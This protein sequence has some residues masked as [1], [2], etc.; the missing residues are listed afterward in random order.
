MGNLQIKNLPDQLHA[1]L[2]RRARRRGVSMRDYVLALIER[3]QRRQSTS[4]WLDE[5]AVDPPVDLVPDVAKT[6][7]RARGDRDDA[8][9][10]AALDRPATPSGD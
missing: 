1:E 9:L 2:R 4:E 10:R 6:I 7:R 8:V 3:D 5:I